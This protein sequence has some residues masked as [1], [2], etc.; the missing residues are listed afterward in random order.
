LN[1]LGIEGALS[2]VDHVEELLK[3]ED[4]TFLNSAVLALGEDIFGCIV[5]ESPSDEPYNNPSVLLQ[6]ANDVQQ[7]VEIILII[8]RPFGTL[9]NYSLVSN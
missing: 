1:H 4:Q 3:S 8:L 5:G 2:H 9:H 7:L 6:Y